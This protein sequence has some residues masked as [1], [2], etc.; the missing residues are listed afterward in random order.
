MIKRLL[1]DS[2]FNV[3]LTVLK[4][5]GVLAKGL[6]KN[7]N[8]EAKQLFNLVVLKFRDK[9]IQMIDETLNTL[10]NF[11]YCISLEEVGDDIK[12]SLKDKVAGVKIKTIIWMTSMICQKVEKI[13]KL[14]EFL[15]SS[16]F[17]NNF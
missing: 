3:V 6:R 16:S 5:I 12:V 15:K 4:L 14:I 8:Y 11:K 13:D 17:Q 2:N 10:T 7:F 1:G 9:K